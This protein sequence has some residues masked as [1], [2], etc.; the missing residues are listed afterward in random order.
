MRDGASAVDFVK[1]DDARVSVL[2]STTDYFVEHSSSV[3][4]LLLNQ[5]AVRISRD[6]PE[7]K[8]VIT[9]SLNRFHELIAGPNRYVEIVDVPLFPLALNELFDVRVVDIHYRHVRTV[10]LTTLCHKLRCFR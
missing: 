3:Q 8:G 9:S 6:L 10:A 2:P 1:E 4:P 7:S 5:W